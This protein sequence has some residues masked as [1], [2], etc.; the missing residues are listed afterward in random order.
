[1]N[2]V[3][4]FEN[5]AIFYHILSN[6]ANLAH[7][8]LVI[9]I[10][11]CVAK[12]DIDTK[13]QMQELDFED[14]ITNI[15]EVITIMMNL[16]EDYKGIQVT[17]NPEKTMLTRWFAYMIA[18]AYL[19]KLVQF[20]YPEMKERKY[21]A[22]FLPRDLFEE[23]ANKQKL[24]PGSQEAIFQ[25]IESSLGFNGPLKLKPVPDSPGEMFC[26]AFKIQTMLDK[27]TVNKIIEK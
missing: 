18:A 10:R 16:L 4:I 22:L 19:Y 27:L 15:D 8:D 25:T 7:A 13:T 14:Y 17:S 12:L 5:E 9:F 11:D 21:S 24:D 26:M 3:K 23:I 20:A 6:D 2:P 1:M